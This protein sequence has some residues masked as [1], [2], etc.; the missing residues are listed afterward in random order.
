MSMCQGVSILI[1]PCIKVCDIETT[2]HWY[3]DLL[4]FTCTYKSQIKNPDYAILE[5]GELKIYLERD[6]EN[7][8]YG[9]N[10]LIIETSNLDA[11]FEALSSTEMLIM[12][13][14]QE[15]VFGGN[16]FCVKDY[17]DNRIIYRQST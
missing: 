10:T 7:E 17:E 11:T 8:S 16:E 6:P 15:G 14:I 3:V 9:K 12:T 4:E 1:C 5:Y 2:I 13:P